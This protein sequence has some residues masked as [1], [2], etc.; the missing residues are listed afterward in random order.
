MKE[1]DFRARFPNA[2]EM[3]VRLNCEDYGGARPSQVLVLE[4]S[5]GQGQARPGQAT[6]GRRTRRQDLVQ[7]RVQAKAQARAAQDQALAGIRGQVQGH[8]VAMAQARLQAL[9]ARGPAVVKPSGRRKVVRNRNGGTWSEARFFQA[10]R[11]ALRGV[12]KFWVPAKEVLMAARVPWPGPR[13]RKWG[14]VCERCQT[15]NLRDQVEIDH[16][17]PAGACRS[18]AELA[19]FI[20]NLTPEHPAAFQV[21]CLDCHRQ[22]TDK[23]AKRRRE[24]RRAVSVAP[25]PGA[26]AEP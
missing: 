2:S 4:P 19:D 14:F 5:Q 3:A 1:A 17:Q 6:P 15:L 13:G 25:G 11:S 26:G 12:F 9:R 18:L 7:A 21:L 10:I 23:E 20:A 22:K 24:A 16:V 8:L